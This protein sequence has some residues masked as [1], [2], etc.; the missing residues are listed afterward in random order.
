LSSMMGTEDSPTIALHGFVSG[1]HN[2]IS[3]IS[4]LLL[5]ICR[6]SLH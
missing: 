1:D 4:T 5:H 3:N 6:P 2:N